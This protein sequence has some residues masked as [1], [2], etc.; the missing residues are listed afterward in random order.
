MTLDIR[1]LSCNIQTNCDIAD[2]EQAGEYTLCIYLLKMREYYRWEKNIGFNLPLP[3]QE[4]G[5]WLTQKEAHWEQLQL[6][7]REFEPVSLDGKQF[8]PFHTDAINQQL[9]DAGYVYSGG[10]GQQKH[11]HFF[12]GELLKKETHYNIQILVS[13]R[14]FARDLTAPPAFTLNNTVFIRRESLRR[15]IWEK[16]EEW[17]WKQ[18]NP[19]INRAMTYYDIVDNLDSAIE[20]LTDNELETVMLHEI[21]E[22]QASH[23]L[24][25]EW[26]EMIV[27]LPKSQAELMA[28]AVRDH[29]ADCTSTLPGLIQQ[30]KIES[31]HF[32][33]GNF[34]AMRKTLFPALTSA[35]NQWI[36]DNHLENVERTLEQACTH[37]QQLAREMVGIYQQYGQQSAPHI[38]KLVQKNIY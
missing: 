18:S 4:L 3:K 27:N 1:Q 32:Y 19:A 24:G 31:I 13:G 23:L 16:I 37:W 35:Y 5:Q 2:S 36:E 12:L 11:I 14:E 34:R 20:K 33:F 8:D 26:A 22:V 25:E 15:M 9:L 17:Q 28:R 30:E 10:I 21:G 38:E 7:G 6:A 29:I